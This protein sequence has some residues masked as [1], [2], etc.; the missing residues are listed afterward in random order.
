MTLKHVQDITSI[1]A[2]LDTSGKPFY[3]KSIGYLIPAWNA[4][5]YICGRTWFKILHSKDLTEF[6]EV[7]VDP[8]G[9]YGN[10]FFADASSN[11]ICIGVGRGLKGSQGTIGYTPLS[12]YLLCSEDGGEHWFKA[13]ELKYP[14]AIYD[15]V[16]VDDIVAFTARERCSI[17]VSFNGGRRFT[18]LRLASDARNTLYTKIGRKEIF[19]VSSNDQFYYSTDWTKF[20]TV[21]FNTTGLVLRYPTWH[22]GKIFFSGVGNRSWLL[23]FDP[24][25]GRL[26]GVDLTRFTGDVLASRLSVH[27]DQFFVGSETR[28]KLYLVNSKKSLRE[29]SI[30]ARMGLRVAS[31]L[32][33]GVRTFTYFSPKMASILGIA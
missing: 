2:S 12:S 8:T 20:K 26:Y 24:K 7:Y 11:R 10:H 33:R 18:E 1:D 14:S 28:G 29:V 19:I 9:T 15:G 13:Y 6:K 17:F 16:I 22:L 30:G 27:G 21:R 31:L 23:A 5:F 25:S 32:R 3:K 4:D